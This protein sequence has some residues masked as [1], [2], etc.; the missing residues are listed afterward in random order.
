VVL[1]GGNLGAGNPRGSGLIL[2]N[3]VNTVVER[4]VVAHNVTGSLPVP[5]ILNFD[6]GQ[7]NPAGM[8]NVTFRNN[9]V[10][11]WG[12]T[13]ANAEIASDFNNVILN[14]VFDHNDVQDGVDSTY[15]AMLG[16]T[17]PD[18][19]AQIHGS[20]NRWYRASGVAGQ[21]FQIGGVDMSFG[22]FVA[23]IGDSTS[24]F[25]AVAYSDPNRTIAT[26]HASIG[27]A[28]SLQAFLSEARQQSK[29]YWRVQYTANAVNDYVRAGFGL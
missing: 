27:G 2:G 16:S 13:G 21:M 17:T 19:V 3:T 28:P 5:W 25:E 4:N 23:A 15:L 18:L 6:N 7:G 29:S 1:D 14:L 22:D 10:Y 26:Y 8:Q 11:D 24:T 12:G 20:G 9:V